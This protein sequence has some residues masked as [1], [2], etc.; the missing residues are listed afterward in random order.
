MKRLI[1]FMLALAIILSCAPRTLPQAEADQLYVT[2]DSDT[3]ELTEDELWGYRYDTLLYAFNEIYARHGYKFK[4]KEMQ[5]HY[6]QFSWY[7]GYRSDMEAVVADF[8]KYE[9]A[10][11]RLEVEK[12]RN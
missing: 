6:Q 9:N 5:D 8:N 7:S 12:A 4:K 3:R 11:L 2:P 1:V 10:N